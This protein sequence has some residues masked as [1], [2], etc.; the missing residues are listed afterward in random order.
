MSIIASNIDPR[1][2]LSGVNPDS[3]TGHCAVIEYILTRD[4]DEFQIADELRA[5]VKQYFY[6]NHELYIAVNDKLAADKVISKANWKNYL[7]L[8]LEV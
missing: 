8:V 3:V 1:G 5:Y 4:K 2:D 6:S 7:S